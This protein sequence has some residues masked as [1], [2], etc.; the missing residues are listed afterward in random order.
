MNFRKVPIPPFL[1]ELKYLSK[2]YHS[3]KD[4]LRSLSIELTLN[5]KLGTPCW[6]GNLNF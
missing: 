3:L 1:K 2:K 4:D 5:P 6:Q